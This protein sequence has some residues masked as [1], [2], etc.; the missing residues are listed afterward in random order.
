[1]QP[2]F[3]PYLGYFALIKH[4]DQW[5]VFDTPQ[6]IR[7]GWIE[8]N[9]ILKPVEGWQYIRIPLEKFN[10]ATPIN[11]VTINRKEDFKKRILAQL[12]HYKKKAKY[13]DVVIELVSKILSY[14]TD[15]IAALNVH[16]L[17]IICNYIDIPF[18][19]TNF[20][21]FS[22]EI[23]PIHNPDEWALEI[24][25]YLNATEYV[26]L[27]GG[28]ELFDKLKFNN[29]GIKLKF[30]DLQITE[31]D[32]KREFFEPGLSIIDALM[33]NSKDKILTLLNNYTHL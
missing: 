21:D 9:R 14:E 5:I 6:F 13:Y 19:H 30:M 18:Y 10:R 28:I 23:P 20:S 25:K 8:R 24:S 12:Y 17:N 22:E 4:T 16:A 1:M 2:Y 27:P 26:N 29:V 31:Y 32:Q 11:E 3:V 33:F 7:H 15:S